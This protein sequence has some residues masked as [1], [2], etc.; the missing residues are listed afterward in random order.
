MLMNEERWPCLLTKQYLID[1]L[2]NVQRQFTK[3]IKSISNLTYF[4]R[5]SILNLEPLELRRMRFDLIQYYKILNNLAD[6]NHAYYFTYHHPSTSSRES[7]LS[8]NDLY[9]II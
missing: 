4:E 2:E 1:K 7:P 6:I 5:L 9:I 8:Y 3:R